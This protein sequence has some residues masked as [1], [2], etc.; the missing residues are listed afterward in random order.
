MTVS[1]LLHEKREEIL[2]FYAKYGARNVHVFGSAEEG[3]SGAGSDPYSMGT[4]LFPRRS[5]HAS[6][7]PGDILQVQKLSAPPGRGGAKIGHRT[8]TPPVP[9]RGSTPPAPPP[10]S[11]CEEGRGGA[12]RERAGGSA[13]S[14]AAAAGGSKIRV[15]DSLEAW[16]QQRAALRS[17][18]PK[19]LETACLMVSYLL[20]TL[21]HLPLGCFSATT[22]GA[23]YAHLLA[24]VSP[25]TVRRAAETLRTALQDAARQGVI[26]RNPA[27]NVTPPSAPAYEPRLPSADEVRAYLADAR[28]TATPAVYGVYC[29]MASCGLRLGEALG[30]REDACDGA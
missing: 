17:R 2:R 15:R 23:T 8:G 16:V 11:A 27:L 1:E 5:T 7:L 12:Y 29:L 6:Y 22:I 13:T 3:E 4:S 19:T 24:H 28:E 18:R 30:L 14:P 10:S 21:G 9:P 20:P 25:S 26:L